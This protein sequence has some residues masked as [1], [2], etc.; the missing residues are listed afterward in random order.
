[1]ADKVRKQSEEIRQ[2]ETAVE[3]LEAR[4]DASDVPQG[5]GVLGPSGP[6]VEEADSSQEGLE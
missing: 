6:D 1:M 5:A 4:L 2:L 3:E